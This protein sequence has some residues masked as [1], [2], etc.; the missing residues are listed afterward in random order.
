M[1]NEIQKLMTYE[2]NLKSKANISQ[3]HDYKNVELRQSEDGKI[4][5]IKGDDGKLPKTHNVF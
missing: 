1:D 4:L 3:Q 5:E 2:D